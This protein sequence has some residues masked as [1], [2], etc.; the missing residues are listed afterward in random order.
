MPPKKEFRGP[1]NFCEWVVG[2]TIPTILGPEKR[3]RKQKPTKRGVIRVEVTTDDESAEDTLKISYPRDRSSRKKVSTT[4]SKSKPKKVRF[5]Q[6][7]KKS[8]L[9]KAAKAYVVSEA[10]EDED[11]TSDSSAD[12][13]S[14][15]SHS[16][17][18]L[19]PESKLKV[20]TVKVS[21]DSKTDDSSE[22]DSAASSEPSPTSNKNSKKKNNN[23]EKKKKQEKEKVKVKDKQPPKKDKKKKTP[24]PATVETDDSK[25]EAKEDADDESSGSEEDGEKQKQKQKQKNKQQKRSKDGKEEQTEKKQ[26]DKD[27][28]K[29]DSSS[30]KKKDAADSKKEQKDKKAT[31]SDKSKLYPEAMPGPNL[32]RPNLIAPIRAQVVQVED[33]VESQEDPPPNSYYDKANNV[34][35]SYH[36]PVYGGF[37]NGGLYPKRDPKHTALPTG[38]A[39]PLRNPYFYGFNNAPPQLS[40]PGQGNGPEA[41]WPPGAWP[42]MPWPYAPPYGQMP[43]GA[44]APPPVKGSKGAFSDRAGRNNVAPDGVEQTSPFRSYAKNSPSYGRRGSKTVSRHGSATGWNNDGAAGSVKQTS[45]SGDWDQN[46]GNQKQDAGEWDGTPTQQPTGDWNTGATA[47]ATWDTGQPAQ[48]KQSWGNT[49]DQNQQDDAG[50]AVATQESNVMPGT[51]DANPAPTWGDTSMAADTHGAVDQETPAPAAVW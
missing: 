22:N 49:N 16:R 36:G 6:V 25:S 17:V 24:E 42:G 14:D 9:K 48:T 35:R 11:K 4:S 20:H 21:D 10:S 26:A 31:D 45:P 50:P 13:S 30:T 34:L 37:Q 46:S 5:E 32:R 27:D 19:I 15:S 3:S 38:T 51:F 47:Q 33:V 23:D 39:H 1:S 2:T 29:K 8:A 40:R 12:A 7:P 43:P 28:K 41:Q 18:I 44:D